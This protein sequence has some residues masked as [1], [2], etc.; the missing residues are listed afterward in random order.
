M[1]VRAVKIEQEIQNRMKGVGKGN[2][3]KNRR[4][5]MLRVKTKKNQKGKKVEKPKLKQVK[6]Q[7]RVTRQIRKERKI[8]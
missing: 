6:N 8:N 1:K 7:K 3:G 2:K 4:A 5:S